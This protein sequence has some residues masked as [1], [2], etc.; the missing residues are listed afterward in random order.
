M[1]IQKDLRLLR[2]SQTFS[3]E[4]ACFRKMEGVDSDAVRPLVIRAEARIAWNG[5][6]NDGVLEAARASRH[7][8]L[9]IKNG[10]V[11]FRY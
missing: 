11:S 10:R 5:D 6:R 2:F 1:P 9:K 8:R 4:A 3:V 7:P